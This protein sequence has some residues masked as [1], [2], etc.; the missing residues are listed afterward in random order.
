[1][2]SSDR[3]HAIVA[4]HHPHRGSTMHK[5]F[6]YTALLVLCHPFISAFTPR[7][8]ATTQ[9]PVVMWGRYGLPEGVDMSNVVAVQAGY[10]FTMVLNADGTV[11]QWQDSTNGLWPIP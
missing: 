8:T 6:A 4:R 10:D 3:A 1:M 2:V 11:L 5:A 7:A 9:P